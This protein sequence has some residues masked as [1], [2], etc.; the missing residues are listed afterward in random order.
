MAINNQEQFEWSG[1]NCLKRWNMQIV[2]DCTDINC[3]LKQLS[4]IKMMYEKKKKS[5]NV[6]SSM[7]LV[8]NAP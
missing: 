3:E 2:L 4:S 8:D 5:V 6:V 1:W 7:H